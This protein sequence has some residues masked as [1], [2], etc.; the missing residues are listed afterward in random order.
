M[1]NAKQFT[2]LAQYLESGR[3]FR[4]V[5]RVLTNTNEVLG[6]GSIG[7]CMEVTVSKYARFLCELYLQRILEVLQKCWVKDNRSS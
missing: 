4:Q 3:S 2:L 1:N 7:F 5:S 6:I